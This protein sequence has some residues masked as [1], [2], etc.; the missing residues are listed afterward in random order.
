M[1]NINAKLSKKEILE[2]EFEVEYKGYKVEEVDAFLDIVSEDYKYYED[3]EIKKDKIIMDLSKKLD[4]LTEELNQTMATLKL[5]EQQQE[6]L[7][8]K[9]LNSSALI[10]RISALEKTNFNKD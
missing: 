1:A 4:D 10:K 7:A 9:G 6:E 8:R 2:K 3:M 5:T